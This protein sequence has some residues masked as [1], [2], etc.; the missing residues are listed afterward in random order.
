M[1]EQDKSSSFECLQTSSDYNILGNF[2]YKIKIKLI[3]IL[4]SG[5]MQSVA[6]VLHVYS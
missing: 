4:L 5:I 6:L 3:Y 1:Q 2:Y